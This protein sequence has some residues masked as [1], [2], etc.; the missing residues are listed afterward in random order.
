ML[1]KATAIALVAIFMLAFLPSAVSAAG[2]SSAAGNGVTM[3]VT[4]GWGGKYVVGKATPVLV[5]VKN[6]GSEIS[7]TLELLT[8][9]GFSTLVR[10]DVVLPQG[11]E[12]RFTLFVMASGIYG[13]KDF[14]VKLKSNG[15]VVISAVPQAVSGIDPS[16]PL[17][18]ILSDDPS[19]VSYL[20]TVSLFQTG[21]RNWIDLTPEDIYEN[22]DLMGAFSVIAINDFDSSKLTDGQR[23]AIRQWAYS[24]GM[25]ILGAGPGREAAA[26][27]W[28][29]ILGDLTFA[30]SDTASDLTSLAALGQGKDLQATL[31][32]SNIKGNSW[33]AVAADS[34][35][36]LILQKKFGRGVAFLTAFDM[37]EGAL[38]TWA[39]NALMWQT[40]FDR[41]SNAG[42]NQYAPG[43]G[44]NYFGGNGM[45]TAL[46][47]GLAGGG[48]TFWLFA[49]M[50]VIFTI[51]AGFAGYLVL[52]AIGKQKLMWLTVPA[53][54][55]LFAGLLLLLGRNSFG[56][57][58]YL[59]AYTSTDISG[60]VA[61]S[62]RTLGIVAP[63][64]GDYRLSIDNSG[65]LFPET[66]IDP[67]YYNSGQ[68]QAKLPV[69][70]IASADGA[71]LKF[72]NVNLNGS[73]IAQFSSFS[74]QAPMEIKLEYDGTNVNCTLKN[75]S[76][77]T[78]EDVAVVIGASTKTVGDLP[79]GGEQKVAMMLDQSPLEQNIWNVIQQLYP[80]NYGGVFPNMSSQ[81]RED[82]IRNAFLQEQ[83][84]MLM[85]G[86]GKAGAIS[87]H[88]A[89]LG[90][91]FVLG[92]IDKP[93][94]YTI[95]VNGKAVKPQSLELITTIS[96]IVQQSGGDSKL[97]FVKAYAQV[98]ASLSTATGGMMKGNYVMVDSG[99]TA[100]LDFNL[101]DSKALDISDMFFETGAQQGVPEG[102][103][104]IYDWSTGVWDAAVP[105]MHFTKDELSKFI[106]PTGLV[107][108]SVQAGANEYVE[109]MPFVWVQGVKK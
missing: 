72:L 50:L 29:D 1:K 108:L 66:N 100:V 13:P 33:A 98:N 90:Q 91:A 96:P 74:P 5:T 84:N 51:L 99:K 2:N 86:M 80:M 68:V 17:C 61:L 94:D 21:T 75:T 85:S 31:P 37:G 25:L 15:A 73:R 32:I 38:G 103:W 89:E 11:T 87:G 3:A 83:I 35:K 16:T 7:G 55:V 18:G 28:K 88:T 34:G 102:S 81:S 65:L 27:P 104:S 78:I 24:G 43:Y 44:M 62:E 4:V 53:I 107:R 58:P 59:F 54:S 67:G 14:E 41:Y 47:S 20:K 57:P 60:G 48:L 52:R 105:K 97:E 76:A 106:D 39:G 109:C 22:A 10:R 71:E 23:A 19:A 30:G 92:W 101:A 6:D 9:T 40:L 26:S 69:T 82:Q 63:A 8:G 70:T 77:W 56:R 93:Y 45:L 12:K 95:K 49:L 42:A 46:R 36:P 79:P 64:M